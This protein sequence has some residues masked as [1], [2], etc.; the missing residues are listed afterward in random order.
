M[1]CDIHFNVEKKTETGWVKMPNPLRKCWGC[2]GTG[3][4]ENAKEPF[5]VHDYRWDEELGDE[6]AY[7]KQTL[8]AGTCS[9]CRGTGK[10]TEEFYHGRNYHLFA[11]LAGVRDYGDTKPIV[12][13]RGVPDDMSEE[14]AKDFN[15]W[16]GDAHSPTWY[17]LDELLKHDWDQNSGISAG[18]VTL[19]QFQKYLKTKEPPDSYCQGIGGP[20]IVVVDAAW[21]A[22]QLLHEKLA[23]KE[24][25]SSLNKDLSYH[26]RLTWGET[27]K[28]MAG[29]HFLKVISELK[30][31]ADK[32]KLP[33]THVRIT[34]WF[35]N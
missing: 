19:E 20:G 18:I 13:P 21:L 5:E 33:Y 9:W 10:K 28:E 14:V 11:I 34:M 35:D 12:P 32:E 6:V 23:G 17:F 15:G 7:N 22:E 24:P 16:G 30:D 3:K 2:E 27:Y 31:I 25:G 29:E 1:G 4:N 26:V 8:P